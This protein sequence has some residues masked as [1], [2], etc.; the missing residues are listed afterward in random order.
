[1]KNDAH[2]DDQLLLTTYSVK[3]PSIHAE[4]L[5]LDENV[6]SVEEDKEVKANS[7]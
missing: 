5:N 3:L 6:A 1:L 2:E 4:K 7:V